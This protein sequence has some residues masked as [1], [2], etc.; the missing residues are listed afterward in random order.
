MASCQHLRATRQAHFPQRCDSVA[1][2][3]LTPEIWREH[4][5]ASLL[6]YPHKYFEISDHC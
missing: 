5:A 2:Q 6:I 3:S 4:I 1:S